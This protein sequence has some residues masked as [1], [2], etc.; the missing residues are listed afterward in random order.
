M[1]LCVC[2]CVCLCVCA[3][4]C[5]CVRVSVCVC[6]CV[7][8]T[9]TSFQ[10]SGLAFRDD[11]REL[12]QCQFFLLSLYKHCYSPLNWV[13]F[14]SLTFKSIIVDF[15]IHLT[16]HALYIVLLFLLIIILKCALLS[17]FTPHYHSAG[18]R[19]IGMAACI[20]PMRAPPPS[21]MVCAC[22]QRGPRVCVYDKRATH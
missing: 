12:N 9:T 1:C 4:V 6:V 11:C 22:A 5:V 16:F 20:M 15:Y 21:R 2:V 8:T 19:Y 18:R 17:N 13:H 10:W 7:C 14:F 3:C